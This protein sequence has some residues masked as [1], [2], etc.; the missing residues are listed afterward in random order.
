MVL[1][2]RATNRG[3]AWPAQAAWQTEL[4]DAILSSIETTDRLDP[5]A[6]ATEVATIVPTKF[7]RG[8]GNLRST[9]YFLKQRSKM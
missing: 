7:R 6:A 5:A 2:W 4:E 8:R 9:Y 1:A 3:R